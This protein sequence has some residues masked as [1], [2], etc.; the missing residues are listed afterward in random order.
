MTTQPGRDEQSADGFDAENT[1]DWQADGSLVLRLCRRESGDTENE[2]SVTVVSARRHDIAAEERIA[3]H[4]RD[5]LN[6]HQASGWQ[7]EKPAEGFWTVAIEPSRRADFCLQAMYKVEVRG[8]SVQYE[9]EVNWYHLEHQLFTGAKWKRRDVPSDPFL[10]P[11]TLP[12]VSVAANP[13][14]YNGQTKVSP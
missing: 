2:F 11:I 3:D 4:I 8:D 1:T 14:G 7:D 6:L 10:S 12:S 9:G 5:A 13:D